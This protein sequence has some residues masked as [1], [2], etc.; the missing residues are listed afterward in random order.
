MFTHFNMCHCNK[1]K[2]IATH[3]YLCYP[4]QNKLSPR[5][6]NTATNR[7]N[8]HA[9]AAAQPSPKGTKEKAKKGKKCQ[10]RQLDKNEDYSQPL[11]PPENTTH[12]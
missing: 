2:S 11:R 7:Y 8:K 4:P 5:Y 6:I 10:H 1:K 12:S 9:G 3:M